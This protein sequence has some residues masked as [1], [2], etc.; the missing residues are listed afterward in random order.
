[1]KKKE[2]EQI[3]S[4]K[5]EISLDERKKIEL[6][7]LKHLKNVCEKNNLKYYLAYGTLLGAVRHKGFIPWDD[8]IDV[9]LPYDDYMKL[10]GILQNDKKYVVID[11]YHNKECYYYFSKLVDPKTIMFE[12]KLKLINKMGVFIDIFPICNLP[13]DEKK[14]KNYVIKINK[15][16]KMAKRQSWAESYYVSNNIIK[17]LIKFFLFLPQHI[18]SVVTNNNKRILKM[19]DQSSKNGSN[20]VVTGPGIYGINEI[21]NKEVFETGSLVEFENELFQAPKDWN[22]VLTKTYGNYMELP[23]EEKRINPHI[24]KAYYR[25]ND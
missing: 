18:F 25:N 7:I 14:R 9:A 22:I 8:D 23:P 12:D 17:S 2:L 11:P 20:F 4:K 19:I 21:I 1:M 16:I 5:K 10:I 3:Y 13:D 6:G 24:T 15:M